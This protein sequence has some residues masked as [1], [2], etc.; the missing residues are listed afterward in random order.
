MPG[1]EVDERLAAVRVGRLLISHLSDDMLIAGTVWLE[2]M[3][4]PRGYQIALQE[5]LVS[6]LTMLA[7][8]WR[9]EADTD[10]VIANI[11][12]TIAQLLEQES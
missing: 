8:Y 6:S 12:K 7:E 1:T 9:S 11:R 2:L 3:R 4:D 10:A 5:A